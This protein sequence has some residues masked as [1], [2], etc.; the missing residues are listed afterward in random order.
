MANSFKD[1]VITPNI[2]NSADPN[3]VFNGANATVNASITLYMYP[4]ANGTLSFEGTAGQLLSIKNDLSN[5]VFTA[6][7]V[8]GNPLIAAYANGQVK[9]APIY[10]NTS[11]GP[12]SELV[13]I[14]KRIAIT[15]STGLQAN[16]VLGTAGQV[17]TTN[18]TGVFWSTSTGGGGGGA[19]VDATYVWTNSH[20]FTANTIT[21]K[22]GPIVTIG[23]LQAYR[24][25]M[26]YF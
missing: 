11:I 16:G 21:I 22:D 23:R 25:G 19:N 14:T 17:L 7:D 9:I 20:N 10:G 1:I 2:A 24:Y 13:V 15:N 5:D 3:I 18:G 4:A 6:S 8:G 26:F 12:N